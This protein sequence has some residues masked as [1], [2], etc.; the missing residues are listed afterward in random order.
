MALQGNIDSFS[1]VDVL[2]LLGSSQK[3]GRLVVDGDRGSASL[4]L[5]AGSLVG[6]T[7]TRTGRPTVGADPAEVLFDIM[8]FAEGAFLFEAGLEPTDAAMPL[9]VAPL[10]IEP[11]IAEATWAMD[12]WAEIV[13]VVPSLWARLTVVRELATPSV[14][15]DARAWAGV[16]AIASGGA[17]RHGAMTVDSLAEQLQLGELPAMRLARDLHALGVVVVGEEVSDGGSAPAF[18][19]PFEA[20]SETAFD[21]AFDSSFD[22]AFDTAFVTAFEASPDEPVTPPTFDDALLASPEAVSPLLAEPMITATEAEPSTFEPVTELDDIFG[23]FDPFGTAS[24]ATGTASAATGT[25]SA[26]NGTAAGESTAYEA[27]EQ[28]ADL[29]AQQA[30]LA[31]QLAMLSPRAAE[32]VASAEAGPPSED[33]ERARVARFLGS[34]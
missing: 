11:V 31:R 4:W 20:P 29:E 32:A 33:E 5:A 25:A 7:T 17:G 2:R 19:A 34:V 10:E 3:S 15:L 21:S 12:E 26:A 6:G 9:R 13:A 27:A 28:A 30:D 18:D 24:A 14:E 1:V 8:R 16:C 23:T 22:T